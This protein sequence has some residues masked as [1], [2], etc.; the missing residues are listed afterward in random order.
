MGN[1]LRKILKALEAQGFTVHRTTK[2]HFT[3]HN[4]LGD[5]VATISGTPSDHRSIKNTIAALR[6]SGFRWPPKR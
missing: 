1:D 3:V 5:L 4:H 2:G 6:R